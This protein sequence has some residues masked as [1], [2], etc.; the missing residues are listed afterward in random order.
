MVLFKAIN[1]EAHCVIITC[2]SPSPYNGSETAFTL[3]FG[4]RFSHLSTH[5]IP[6]QLENYEKLV[7]KTRES[8]KENFDALQQ[9]EK[10]AAGRKNRMYSI[11]FKVVQ[12][13]ASQLAFLES[14][15]VSPVIIVSLFS[16]AVITISVLEQNFTFI[17]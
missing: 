9:L 11:R 4:E 10:S 14:L 15:L 8:L 6:C 16:P 13:R 7:K 3:D 5:P 2:I 17:L 1:G 12:A